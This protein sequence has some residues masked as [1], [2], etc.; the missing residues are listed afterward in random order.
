MP[1]GAT[2]DGDGDGET[3]ALATPD[4]D[5]E[6]R[7][8]DVGRGR[9]DATRVCPPGDLVGCDLYGLLFLAWFPLGKFG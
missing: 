3:R 1:D 5:G 2:P 4:G 6:M 8:G 7:A 9:G